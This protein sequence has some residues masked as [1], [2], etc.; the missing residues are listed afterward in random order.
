[1]K[2]R[3]AG[4]GSGLITAA[5]VFLLVLLSSAGCGERPAVRPEAVTVPEV[6]PYFDARPSELDGQGSASPESFGPFPAGSRADF[7]IEFTVGEAGIRPGGFILLQ[8]SPWWGWSPPHPGDPEIPGA[9]SVRA[10]FAEPE[11]EVKILPLNR[12]LV[13]SPGAAIPAG[14]RIEFDYLNAAVDRFAEEEELF[15]FF[16]DVD[17]D[18]HAAPIARQPRI[19]IAAAR[20]V[21]LRVSVPPL[22]RPGE[23]ITVRAAPLDRFGN[24]SGLE[25]GH[26]ALTVETGD[27]TKPE[28]AAA[29][30]AAGGEKT[31]SFAWT[32]EKEGIYHFR[33]EG[34][35]GLSGKSNVLLCREGEPKLHLYFGDIHGHSRLSD[36]TGTPEDFYR[37]AREV[38]GLEIAALT[39][40]ADFGTIRIEAEVWER[41]TA[42]ANRAYQPGKFVTL[43]GFEWTSWV[44]G[45]RNVYYRG[46][47]GPIFSSL[48]PE[49][50]TPQKLWKLLEPYPAMTIAH[51]AGGGPIA[52]DW[53]I[54]PGEIERLVEISSIHGTSE[55]FGGEYSIYRPVKGTFVIDALERGYRL[56]LIG[57][58]DNHDGHPG[59]GSAGAA[60]TGLMGIYASGLTREE[61]W[62]ALWN[63][64]V[65]ATTGAKIILNFRVGDRPMGSEVEWPEEAA[66]LP[67]ALRAV[68]CGPLARIE[69]IRNG[70]VIF[71]EKGDGLLAGLLL[72]DPDPPAGTSW[73]Y[74]K[75]VQEDGQMAWSSPVWVTVGPEP[76]E[77]RE[78]SRLRAVALQ[79]GGA[80]PR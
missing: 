2:P 37:Y 63:R 42:A 61:V 76:V 46:E 75:I 8:I 55:R 51:H 7:R 13:F 43:V 38:S 31:L 56:G 17:G 1:M 40:H 58:G 73:Y 11:L 59:N 47:G 22:A 62:E 53:E 30:G 79:R 24:W 15:Q 32:P 6:V 26:Y 28:A 25:T 27:E 39:D 54:P 78:S 68:G 70:E 48:D 5:A 44:Y 50:D 21:R 64:R 67:I 23:A 52:V 16:T 57:S 10:E 34:P 71:A 41:I 49:S 60:V 74:L 3:Q 29:R 33:I 14:S 19:R 20:P 66:P 4:A 18:G 69:V 80:D 36:G 77:N 72:E 9:V 12:V 45:H 65:Y 35:G